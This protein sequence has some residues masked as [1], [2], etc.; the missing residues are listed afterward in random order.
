MYQRRMSSCIHLNTQPAELSAK[1]AAIRWTAK[2]PYAP[3]EC[4]AALAATSP[5]YA[6]LSITHPPSWVRPPLS[7]E[8]NTVSSLSVAFEDP[9]GSKL[10]S[11]L[12]DRYLYCF[13]NRMVVKAETTHHASRTPPTPTSKLPRQPSK[14]IAPLKLPLARNRSSNTQHT[15]PTNLHPQAHP[16]QAT[17]QETGQLPVAGVV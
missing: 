8:Q 7:Y 15:S 13:S 9:D 12:A 11:M 4:H 6:S 2:G 3:A 5:T 16:N 17:Q 10:R 14:R 1:I